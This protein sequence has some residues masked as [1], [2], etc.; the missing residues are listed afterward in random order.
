MLD[1]VL[2]HSPA[3]VFFSIGDARPFVEKVR[4][5][6]SR[7]HIY[8]QVQTV[9]EAV[10]ASEYSDCIVAQGIESGGHGRRDACPT[11]PFVE[12]VC[13]ALRSM[14]LPANV[15]IAEHTRRRSLPV[16]AA[17]GLVDGNDIRAA[18]AKGASGVMMGTRFVAS[19]ECLWPLAA[20]RALLQAR[21]TDTVRTDIFDRI[22]GLDWPPEYD[23]RAL[24]HPV[25]ERWR[26]R[27]HLLTA[28]SLSQE[29]RRFAAESIENT[30][31]FCGTSVDRVR[32]ILPAADIVQSLSNEFTGLVS[33]L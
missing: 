15:S 4:A 2:K 12:D 30:V 13:R 29:R 24:T 10:S 3:A 17:G 9:P 21:A 14:P 7:I 11:L 6:S 33:R 20:K 26:G 16:I 19:N 32:R 8:S 27:E 28:A 22:R 23:G 5:H 1:M 18:F 25:V 31:L